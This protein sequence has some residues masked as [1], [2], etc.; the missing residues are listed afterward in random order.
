MTRRL[1]DLL[2]N[3]RLGLG[4][5]LLV[6]PVVAVLTTAALTWDVTWWLLTG[7]LALWVRRQ[8]VLECPA[9]HPVAVDEQGLWACSRCKLTY[10]GRPFQPCPHCGWEPRAVAC[11]CGE[12]VTSPISAV[13]EP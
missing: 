3:T 13:G 12:V 10:T 2:G 9:G 11:P 1:L 4:A 6:S 5:I 8:R 7:C